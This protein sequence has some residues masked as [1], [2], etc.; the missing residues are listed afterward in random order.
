MA[1]APVRSATQRM[2]CRDGVVDVT[3][4]DDLVTGLESQG[5][6]YGIDPGRRIRHEAEVIRCHAEEV[7]D[8]LLRTCEVLAAT[9]VDPLDGPRFVGPSM[10][11]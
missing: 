3:R 9:P 2:V 4:R 11:A 10:A 7:A 8:D 6:E 1:R 5:A